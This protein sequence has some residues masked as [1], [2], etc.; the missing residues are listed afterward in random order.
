LEKNNIH[1]EIIHSKIKIKER[2][3]I[4]EKWGIEFFPLLSVHTLEIGYDIPHVKIAI[5]LSNTSNINQIVQRIGR[6]IRKTENKEKALIY[7]IYAKETKDNNMVRMIDKAVGKKS[8]KT[9]K[10]STKQ[11][12]ITDKFK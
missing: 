12:K 8:D 11:T 5:I 9:Y 1:S 4:L 2:K 3:S 6:V 7:V 10:K